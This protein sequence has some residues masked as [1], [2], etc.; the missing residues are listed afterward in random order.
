MK[1]VIIFDYD[2]VII[3]SL[4][5]VL[6]IF[7]TIGK[8]YTL[9]ITSQKELEAVFD[10]NFYEGLKRHGLPDTRL[11]EFLS[12]F[13]AEIMKKQKQIRLFEGVKEC[14]ATLSKKNKLMIVTSNLTDIVTLFL[15]QQRMNLFEEILGADNHT[16]KVQKI[17]S[18]KKKYPGFKYFYVGDTMG[19]IKEGKQ[20][21]V[22]T[23]ATTWGYH[24]RTKLQ[25]QKPDY[26]VDSPSQLQEIFEE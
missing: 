21:G 1:R 15:D 26:I 10:T 23:I 8:K 9:K 7:E 16:S 24:N 2:G 25:G 18:I 17:L 5:V 12:E 13:T 22:Q 3:D 4:A 6:T 19:D 11:Q 14:I 20:A